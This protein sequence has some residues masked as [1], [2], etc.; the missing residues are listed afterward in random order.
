MK[1][2]ERVDRIEK[3]INGNGKT[4]LKQTVTKLVVQNEMIIKSMEK[5]EKIDEDIRA[6]LSG[7]IKFQSEFEG[8]QLQKEKDAIKSARKRANYNWLVGILITIILTLT[9]FLL[10]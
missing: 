10:V 5:R 4:G 7:F 3:E 1:I 6:S 9:G 8:M 2:D